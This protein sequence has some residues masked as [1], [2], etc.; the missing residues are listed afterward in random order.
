MKRRTAT[1]RQQIGARFSIDQAAGSGG[2]FR[3]NDNAPESIPR[4]PARERFLAQSKSDVETNAE[5][6][7]MAPRAWQ[8][9]P[10][11]LFAFGEL[12]KF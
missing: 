3:I 8:L 12:N 6:Q 9:D 10:T 2:P 1:P 4:T 11:H 7:G 5:I